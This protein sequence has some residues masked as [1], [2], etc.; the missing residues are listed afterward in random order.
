MQHSQTFFNSA[1]E[2]NPEGELA[3]NI[4][5]S[6]IIEIATAHANALGIGNPTMA[7]LD[8]GW[9]LSR[10]TI[11]MER[12]PKTN[13]SYTLRTWVENW[14]RH[15]STRD[16]SIEDEQ[17]NVI[18]YARSVWMVLNMKTHENFGLSHL[19][20]PDGA[21]SDYPCPIAPQGRHT[22]IYPIDTPADEVPAKAL[23]ASAPAV[24]YTFKYN[25][26]DFY[27][28]VNTVRYVTI[29]LNQYSLQDFDRKFLHRMELSFLHEGNFG[30]T[31]TVFRHDYEDAGEERTDYSL[32]SHHKGLPLIFARL[33][34]RKR[35][36]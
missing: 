34:L 8:A 12:Y 16:F 2:S 25:D 26:I 27:R 19:M 3:V 7:H 5:V 35:E 22:E 10:L 15:F 31:V 17:G 6:N 30:D 4:L 11:E 24:E 9:V 29:L 21:V 32:F 1:N 33:I 13:E 23:R 36:Q 20:L 14:N 28:H 18:G